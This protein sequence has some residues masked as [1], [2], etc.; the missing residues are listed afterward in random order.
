MRQICGFK[1]PCLGVFSTGD[2]L[3]GLLSSFCH[4]V[5]L[6]WVQHVYI[7]FSW[8]V[9]PNISLRKGLAPEYIHSSSRSTVK[10][11]SRRGKCASRECNAEGI[12]LCFKHLTRKELDETLFVAA[13][14]DVDE[15]KGI[16]S[17]SVIM[18]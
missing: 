7:N 9:S 5:T 10:W 18:D 13:R 17:V 8:D 15:T 14:R 4:F 2:D 1:N 3:R 12:A 6:F 11:T 16:E